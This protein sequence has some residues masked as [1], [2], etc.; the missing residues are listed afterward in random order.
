ML[1]TV[2]RVVSGGCFSPA[3]VNERTTSASSALPSTDTTPP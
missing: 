3:V 2:G 1:T